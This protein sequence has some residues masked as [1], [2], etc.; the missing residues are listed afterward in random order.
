MPLTVLIFAILV[1]L[2]GLIDFIVGDSGDRK[3]KERMAEYYVAV[4]DGDWTLLYRYPCSQLLRFMSYILGPDSLSARCILVTAVLSLLMTA[5]FFSLSMISSYVHSIL[6][7]VRCPVP[8]VAQFLEIPGYM[9]PFL[10]YIAAI[11]IVFDY[12]SWTVTRWGLRILSVDRSYK[13]VTVAIAI[14]LLAGLLLWSMYAIYL[15]LTIKVQANMMGVPFDWKAFL[16]IGRANLQNLAGLFSAPHY[17]FVLACGG[18]H[19]IFDISFINTM[20]ILATETLIPIVL[21]LASSVVGLVVYLTRSLTGRLVSYALERL[22]DNSSKHVC[23]V[24]AGLISLIYA[25]LAAVT[26]YRKG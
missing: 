10:F 17:L 20:Q 14:P 23:T 4:G 12:C 26:S 16:Q 15:P 22:D 13:S 6:V 8:G 19:S 25:L 21:F 18:D 1:A 11:N 2:G 3:A 9:S 5:I 7:D 24:V